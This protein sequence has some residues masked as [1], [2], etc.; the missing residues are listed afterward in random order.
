M[1][2]KID[3]ETIERIDINKQIERQTGVKSRQLE[4]TQ[5]VDCRL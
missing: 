4:G 3:G 5:T 1:D 2:T